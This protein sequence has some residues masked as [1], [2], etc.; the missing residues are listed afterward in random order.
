MIPR[1]ME[2]G[3][4]RSS[5]CKSNRNEAKNYFVVSNGGFRIAQVDNDTSDC[6]SNSFCDFFTIRKPLLIEERNETVKKPK[7]K[8][9]RNKLQKSGML[10]SQKPYKIG[11]SK[12]RLKAR[13]LFA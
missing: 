12:K 13:S 8:A 3:L 9:N 11:C 10:S 6:C 7:K 5:G 4:K 2:V 1:K